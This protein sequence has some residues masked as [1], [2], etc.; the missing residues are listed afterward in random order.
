[1][2]EGERVKLGSEGIKY[3]GNELKVDL[4][5][6]GK[7][8]KVFLITSQRGGSGTF[9]YV[10]A[11]LNTEKGYVGSKG[12]FLGD[13]IAPQTTEKGSGKI[14]IVNYADRVPGQPFAIEPSVGKSVWL[15]FDSQALQFG[16]VEKDFEGEAN[17]AVMKLTMK[18]WIWVSALYND[19]TEIVPKK[20]GAFT[21]TFAD[22]G[23]FTAT[24]DCNSMIGSYH[25]NGPEISF[26]QIASTEMYCEGSQE[27]DFAKLLEKAQMY[28]F[29]S[30]GE[31]VI[32]LRY[33][34]G[35]AT[36]R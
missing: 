6:D 20:A 26:S 25:A 15:I 16:E 33:D 4:N 11:T 18:T 3:F 7:I 21:V 32:D 29:T 12:F 17:P 5:A 8:D 10:V 30:K 19:G 13:R 35:T 24:T 28:L 34:S 14:I 2:I 1:M 27:G 31:L 22:N 36:F 23:K 9:Y